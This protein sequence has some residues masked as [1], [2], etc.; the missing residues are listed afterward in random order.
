MLVQF[1]PISPKHRTQKLELLL[2]QLF[3]FVKDDI[4][5]EQG[6]ELLKARII[7]VFLTSFPRN[8]NRNKKN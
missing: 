4:V 5:E 1:V 2:V 6:N 3:L 7:K 8:V